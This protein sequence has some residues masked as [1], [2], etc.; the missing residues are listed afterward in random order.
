VRGVA[1]GLDRAVLP[2]V[3]S[4]VNSGVWEA[5]KVVCVCVLCGMR[6]LRYDFADQALFSQHLHRFG[7][8]TQASVDD[9]LEHIIECCGSTNDVMHIKV[10]GVLHEVIVDDK[11]TLAAWK[12]SPFKCATLVNDNV[13]RCL[14]FARLWL[15][16]T[17]FLFGDEVLS[18]RDV[19]KDCAVLSILP[20]DRDSTTTWPSPLEEDKLCEHLTAQLADLE[21]FAPSFV[22]AVCYV[23]RN[24]MSLAHGPLAMWRELWQGADAGDK[25][26]HL[27]VY[28]GILQFDR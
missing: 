11:S 27:T 25:P 2:S 1:R 15:H 4:C 12:S 14:F 3:Q 5:C 20:P 24:T 16:S 18:L 21:A 22:K 7:S 26:R 6:L 23:Y 8:V 10:V 9:T 13:P 19:E 17:A 28:D